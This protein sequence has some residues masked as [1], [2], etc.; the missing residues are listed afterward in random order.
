MIYEWALVLFTAIL[1]WTTFWLS[2]H[3]KSLS[4]QTSALVDIERK[5]DDRENREKK[6]TEIKAGLDAAE[7]VQKIFPDN[8]SSRLAKPAD[9]PLVEMN[10]IEKL[11]SIKRYIVDENCRLALAQLCGIFDTARR[12]KNEIR[13]N[14]VE[15]TNIIKTLQKTIQ[16]SVDQWRQEISN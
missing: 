5:R 12:E 7:I 14:H 13:L 2:V 3:T 11:H 4:K 6:L 15:I 8:F 16:W 10:A 9:Y 1:A